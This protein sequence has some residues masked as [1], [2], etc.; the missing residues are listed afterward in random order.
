MYRRREAR[1]GVCP[2]EGGHSA[3]TPGTVFVHSTLHGQLRTC[4]PVSACGSYLHSLE[5]LKWAGSEAQATGRTISHP[6][7]PKETQEGRRR[8]TFPAE[9]P[10]LGA[11]L[12][13]PPPYV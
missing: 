7:P 12:S 6:P 8:N 5:A 9:G 4:G 3:A 11:L 10:D 13:L 1:Q 2:G